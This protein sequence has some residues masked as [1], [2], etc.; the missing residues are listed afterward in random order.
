[1]F[2]YPRIL[3]LILLL[4]P[5]L[6]LAGKRKY[7]YPVDSHGHPIYLSQDTWVSDNRIL[8]QRP[9]SLY[10]YLDGEQREVIPCI[11]QFAEPFCNGNALVMLHGKYGVIDTNG[12]EVIPA[13]FKSI[14]QYL[15]P[16][17]SNTHCFG[18]LVGVETDSAHGIYDIKEHKFYPAAD[19]NDAYIEHYGYEW[20]RKISKLKDKKWLIGVVNEKS[21]FVLPP[22][23]SFVGGESEWPRI[24]VVRDGKWG[25]VNMSFQ[26]TIP[27][28][29]DS[30][31]RFLNG[32]APVKMNGKWGYIN[33]AGQQV[34]SYIYDV[35]GNME[36]RGIAPVAVN[37]SWGAI[38]TIGNIIISLDNQKV[39]VYSDGYAIK[40][41]GKWALADAK[42]IQ[43][44]AFIY[45]SAWWCNN[46]F[47]VKQRGLFGL[48]SKDFRD[49]LPC[50][51]SLMNYDFNSGNYKFCINDQWGIAN[52]RGE[53]LTPAAFSSDFT[54]EMYLKNLR[55]GYKDSLRFLYWHYAP[56]G[57]FFRRRAMVTNSAGLTGFINKRGK[58][59]I[60]SQ[61]LRTRDFVRK[62]TEVLTNLAEDEDQVDTLDAYSSPLTLKYAL[63]NRKG[64][65]VTKWHNDNVYCDKGFVTTT[66]GGREG[67]ST[68][69]GKVIVP[70][71]YHLARALSRN[72]YLV[73]SSDSAFGVINRRGRVIVPL[74]NHFLN[75]TGRVYLTN[76]NGRYFS[77]DRH[78]RFLR[79]L[80]SA[81]VEVGAFENG[82][83]L[84]LDK[85][86]QSGFVNAKGELVIPIKYRGVSGFHNGFAPVGD[87]ETDLIGFINKSGEIVIPFTYADAGLY[88]LHG[89]TPVKEPYK[90]NY[91]YIDKK[92]KRV[93]PYMFSRPNSYDDWGYTSRL[94]AVEAYGHNYYINRKGRIKLEVHIP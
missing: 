74:Q 71:V 72:R 93:T 21:E 46:A 60:P 39:F 92:G 4:F 18:V 6:A 10:G 81:I 75:Y 24:R 2:R 50:L 94:I 65:L 37:G 76:K 85:E 43:R 77:L 16:V 52:C 15:P 47:V 33:A 55:K 89:L 1:M 38:D 73:A 67:L 3:L 11:Y 53:Y 29:F 80:D 42:G 58:L 40:R 32:F 68:L 90:S 30:A 57:D 86:R 88:N 64:R 61:Y 12:K 59:V 26:E 7:P 20:Y 78:G 8:V 13:V 41:Y 14:S 28:A 54:A 36:S 48:R 63:I 22:I 83:G 87:S 91:A 19:Y 84:V 25:F 5:L 31:K 34:V 82:R 17:G 27:P 70:L 69:H 23:Y 35:A 56:A 49:S 45:D 79:F 9:D 51:Y 44:T 62:Y 66:D